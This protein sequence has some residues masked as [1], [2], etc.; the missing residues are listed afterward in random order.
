MTKRVSVFKLPPVD[1]PAPAEEVVIAGVKALQRGD[2]SAHQQAKVFEWIIREA[3]GLGNPSY[4]P[5]PYATAF[6]E[7]RRFV[8]IQMMDLLNKEAKH[9]D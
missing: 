5:D 2:A 9:G 7:G 8:A 1:Q 3:S 4:R 6:A